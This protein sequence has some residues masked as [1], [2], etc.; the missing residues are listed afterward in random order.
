M[1]NSFA[2]GLTNQTNVDKFISYAER[3]RILNRANVNG[4]TFN[5]LRVFLQYA[6]T[7]SGLQFEGSD[8]SKNDIIQKLSAKTGL[9]LTLSQ[10]KDRNMPNSRWLNVY[11]LAAMD[12]DALTN[13]VYGDLYIP[14]TLMEVNKDKEYKI[15]KKWIFPAGSRDIVYSFTSDF[16]KCFWVPTGCACATDKHTRTINTPDAVITETYVKN[17]GDGYEYSLAGVDGASKYHGA[18]MTT[19]NDKREVVF[20]WT[21]TYQC[22][23]AE[24][25]LRMSAIMAGAANGM[26]AAFNKLFVVKSG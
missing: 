11:C 4:T 18:M 5:W 26:N 12:T 13:V 15:E 6:H 7:V 21:C 17:N 23:N 9:P 24:S 22:E 25:I 8:Y 14:L 3:A 2:L 20:I 10:V 16:C 1:K 19:E